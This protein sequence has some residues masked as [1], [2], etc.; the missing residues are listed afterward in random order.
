MYP[1]QSRLG[2]FWD[3]QVGLGPGMGT[4]LAAVHTV[5]VLKGRCTIEDVARLMSENTARRFDLYP[6]KGAL[7]LGADADMIVFDP[8][9]EKTVQADMLE[10]A[11]G[12]SLYEGE[13][14]TGWPQQVFVRGSLVFDSGKIVAGE[15]TGRHVPP[16]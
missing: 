1:H 15:P 9:A 12:Y 7:A 3:T 10:T 16:S 6:Q 13:M 14:L 8:K 4:S 11:A 5:G 2:D